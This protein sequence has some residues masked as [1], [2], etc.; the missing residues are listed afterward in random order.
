M[1]IGSF[2]NVYKKI[3]NFASV[4]KSLITQDAIPPRVSLGLSYRCNARCTFCDRW[5]A[6]KENELITE[7]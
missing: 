1:K 6:S 5:K 3:R 2:V 4:Y 7:E